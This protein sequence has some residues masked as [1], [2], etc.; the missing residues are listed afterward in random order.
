MIATGGGA[1]LSEYNRE[2]MKQA[3]Q[4]IWLDA[5]AETLA[6]RI[7]GDANR[8]LLHDVDPLEKMRVLTAERNPLY[9]E[10]ADL[11]IDTDEMNIK[12][13]VDTIASFMSA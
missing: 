3:G 12:Q 11:R 13:A 6:R 7:R 8:P 2:L 9:A 1:I 5:S 4:V 10:I